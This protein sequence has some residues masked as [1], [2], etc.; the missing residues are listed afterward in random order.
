MGTGPCPIRHRHRHRHLLRQCRLPRRLSAHCA[1]AAHRIARA[2]ASTPRSWTARAHG[3]RC[4]AAPCSSLVA[5]RTSHL[6]RWRPPVTLPL[7]CLRTVTGA[8]LSGA[9]WGV[10]VCSQEAAH[11]RQVGQTYLRVGNLVEARRHLARAE[12][13]LQIE[14]P[15]VYDEPTTAALEHAHKSRLHGQG[16]S[17]APP[18]SRTRLAA[19]GGSALVEGEPG[20]LWASRRLGLL[21]TWHHNSRPQSRRL[22]TALGHPGARRGESDDA[23]QLC[24]NHAR[25]QPGEEA[26]ICACWLDSRVTVM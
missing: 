23:R 12:Q 1:R 19:L 22:Q 26:M 17:P 21:S 3:C 7:P 24:V 4:V 16:P 20:P 11:A 6:P 8:L 25:G 9:D 14:T 2:R 10:A 5:R 15:N 13:L 18:P